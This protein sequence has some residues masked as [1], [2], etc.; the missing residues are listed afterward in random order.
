MGEKGT[1]ESRLKRIR[2]ELSLIDKDLE[3]LSGV[4]S[5]PSPGL[6]KPRIKSKELREKFE[7]N[8]GRPAGKAKVAKGRAQA[9]RSPK[10]P[11]LSAE[12]GPEVD[13][14]EHFLEYLSSSFNSGRPMKHERRIQRNKAVLMLIIVLFILFFVLYRVMS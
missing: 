1:L 11:V 14:D 2:K 12:A 9:Q 5:D 4:A 7:R 6:Q 10:K 13:K 8:A 3:S